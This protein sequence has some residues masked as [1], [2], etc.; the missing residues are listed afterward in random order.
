MSPDVCGKTLSFTH[1]FLFLL[2]QYTTL[3]SHA[4]DGHQYGGLVISKASIIDPEISPTPPLIFTEDQKVRNMASFSH[5]S[6]VSHPHLKMQRD[7]Q[8]LKCGKC[9][10]A[11]IVL[12]SRRVW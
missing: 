4:V 8:T 9:D 11:M 7:I 6:I 2:H 3:S 12:F 5:H 1:E 10:A